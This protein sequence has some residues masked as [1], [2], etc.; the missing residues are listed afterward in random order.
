MP[1]PTSPFADEISRSI[2]VGR[3][4]SEHGRGFMSDACNNERQGRAFH[5]D[6][7]PET[8]SSTDTFSI[9]GLL[10]RGFRAVGPISG[11]GAERQTHAVNSVGTPNPKPGD[12][13]WRMMTIAIPFLRPTKPRT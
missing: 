11:R 8:S 7:G 5:G 3:L 10:K 2:R 1:H 4:R 12:A 6:E 9:R 13:Q